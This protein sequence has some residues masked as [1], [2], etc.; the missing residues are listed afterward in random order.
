MSA[1]IMPCSHRVNMLNVLL[2]RRYYCVSM[3]AAALRR[4]LQCCLCVWRTSVSSSFHVS[5]FE[6]K[7]A[8]VSPVRV[9]VAPFQR[10]R[11]KMQC[12]NTKAGT[13][14]GAPEIDK[15]IN[16]NLRD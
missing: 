7:G 15:K 4:R 16:R 3:D 14:K 8:A 6:F 5:L 12:E 1:E 13:T 9:L 10:G 11:W 2:Q